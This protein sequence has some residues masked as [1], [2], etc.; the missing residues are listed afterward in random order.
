M[1]ATGTPFWRRKRTWFFVVLLLLPFLVIYIFTRSY[2][3]SPIVSNILSKEIGTNVQVGGANIGFSGNLSL[4]DVVL[5]A[6]QIA[7]EASNVITLSEIDI[8]LDSPI[9]FGDIGVESIAIESAT[10]R[11]AE[12]TV[13][14]GDFNFLHLS[15]HLIGALSQTQTGQSKEVEKETKTKFPEFK[16]GSIIV[17]SGVM[18]DG[19]WELDDKQVFEVENIN[20]KQGLYECKLRDAQNT[21]MPE[22]ALSFSDSELH[23][24]VKKIDINH[25]LLSLLPRTARVWIEEIS[26]EGGLDNLT[27]DWMKG[28]GVVAKS[29]IENVQFALPEE[30]GLPWTHYDK[31]EYSQIRGNASLDVNDGVIIYDGSSVVLKDIIGQLVPPNQDEQVAFRADLQI[32]ELPSIGKGENEDWMESMLATAP[33]EAKFFLEDFRPSKDGEANLPLAASRILSLFQLEQWEIQTKASVKRETINSEIIASGELF[34]KG[35]SGAYEGFS[36]PLKDVSA[37]IKFKNDNITIE[38]L[39]AVGSDEATVHINGEVKNANDSLVVDV[40]IHAPSAPLDKE[41]H[42]ALPDSIANVMDRLLDEEAMAKMSEV[43]TEDELKGFSLGGTVELNLNVFHDSNVSSSVLV[44]GDITPQNVGIVHDVFSY[45]VTLKSGKVFLDPEGIYVPKEGAVRFEGRGGGEGIMRGSILFKENGFASPDLQLML[46]HESVNKALIEAVSFSAGDSYNLALNV[47]T[48]L[49][50]DSKLTAVGSVIGNEQDEIDSVF[51]VEFIDGT[52]ILQ[53]S[54][55]QAIHSTGPFWP[56]GFQ[57]EGVK[58]KVEI[59]NGVVTVTSATC[60]CGSGSITA[61]M[62]IDKEDFE[63]ALSGSELPISSRFIDVLPVTASNYLSDSW[64][65]LEPGGIMNA[66]IQI[67]N[68]L[69]Q[70]NLFMNISPSELTVSGNNHTVNL[71]LLNGEIIV[72]NTDV[73]LNDLKFRLEREETDEGMLDIGGSINGDVE[74]LTY[75]IDASWSQASIGSP[76]TRAITGI[77]GGQSGLDYYDS[78]N[79]TGSADATLRAQSDG[80]LSGYIAEI[81]P[82]SISAQMHGYTARAVLSDDGGYKNTIRFTES[83]MVFDE[84]NGVLG[85]GVFTID[86]SSDSDRTIDLTWSGPSED[87]SLYAVLP[88]VVSESLSAIEMKGGLSELDNGVFTLVGESWSDLDVQFD[89]DIQLKDVSI[90]VGIPLK[91]IDG[92][93]NVDAIYNDDELSQMVLGLNVDAMSVLGRPLTNMTGQLI[94][95]SVEPRLV[96][97]NLGGQ[98]TTGGVAIEGWIAVDESKEYEIQV[99][100]AGAK[101]A[102]EEGD[103]ALASLEG[104]LTGWLSIAGERGVSST[105]R[106]SGIVLVRDGSL[107]LDSLSVR[108]MQMLNFSIPTSQSITGVDI[109]LLI[110]GDKIIIENIKLMA[111]E[112]SITDLVLTGDGSVDIETFT[113]NARLRPRVG[114]PIIRDIAGAVNDQL[115]SIDVSGELFNP[116]VSVNPLPALSPREN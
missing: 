26:L 11:V 105:R 86:T 102:A 57:L 9:P 100:I 55:A 35:A 52:A 53:P 41:L 8:K 45:P 94:K 101:I 18:S 107:I 34:I 30:H 22:I 16:L 40:N 19:V 115:Y 109:N 6:D 31:G 87:E 83:G 66:E 73:F 29:R 39:N 82:T 48:G 59:N 58:A 27:V 64:K 112:S 46:D 23:V 54:L 81:V 36:Y 88:E 90:D 106:G 71:E 79:P 37:G 56:P 1:K 38:Y 28:E 65:M 14:A 80:D 47:L 63:L 24:D 17:E 77:I 111:D 113:L 50:L 72:E 75:G 33:F 70:N 2:V 114:L 61:Q 49:G 97:K 62:L 42:D 108:A 89:G 74:N 10:I 7:G 92:S 99:F 84:L 91:D 116:S 32:Y 25:T 103:D 44:S 43:L 60:E 93:V 69:D 67:N 5:K 110:D 95:D 78:I 98:S 96:F 21:E 20:N 12:S 15:D 76:L 51:S 85:E 104:E 3:L 13:N 4:S 68:S